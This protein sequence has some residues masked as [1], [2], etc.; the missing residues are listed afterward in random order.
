MLIIARGNPQRVGLNESR[1]F[2][3]VSFFDQCIWSVKAIVTFNT[4][5]LFQKDKVEGQGWVDN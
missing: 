3:L 2:C 4:I 5:Y 1:V